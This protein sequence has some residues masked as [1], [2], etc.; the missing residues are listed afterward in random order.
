MTETLKFDLIGS[1][2]YVSLVCGGCNRWGAGEGI[3]SNDYTE[4]RNDASGTGLLKG[5]ARASARLDGW[6]CLCA[7]RENGSCA[8]GTNFCAQEHLTAG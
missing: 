6:Q 3:N 4:E 2:G 8:K 1:R 7:S 5:V